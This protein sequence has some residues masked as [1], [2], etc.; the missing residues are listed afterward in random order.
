MINLVRAEFIKLRTTQTWFWLLLASVA[1]TVISVIG[2]TAGKSDLYLFVHRRDILTSASPAYIAVFVLGA[3]AVTTE[4]R[5]QTITPTVLATPSRWRIVGAK[6][7]AYAL[8]GAGYALVCIA[9]ELLMALPWLHARG[10]P[11]Q[12]GDRIGALASVFGLVVLM[13]LVGLGA[14][15]LIRNQVVAV[16]VGVITLLIL[17]NLIVLIPGVKHVYPFLPGGATA[18]MLNGSGDRHINGVELLPIGGGVVVLVVWAVGMAV[19]GAGLTMNR[20]IT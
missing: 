15:A 5:H 13:G 16:A 18:A 12:F 14:G 4:F 3:L 10:I 2:Q 20:D 8:T 17:Q 11:I 1:I 19:L 9:F 6:M 7:I